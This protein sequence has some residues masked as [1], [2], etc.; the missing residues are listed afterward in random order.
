[1]VFQLG[2]RKGPTVALAPNKFGNMARRDLE[3]SDKTGR[4]LD[5]AN[6]F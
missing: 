6:D 1:L 5:N 3:L 4:Y 2:A